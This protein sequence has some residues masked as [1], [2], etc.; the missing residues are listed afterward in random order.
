MFFAAM[1]V[2]M[3][4]VVQRII[5]STFGELNTEFLLQGETKTSFMRAFQV[6]R[7]IEEMTNLS[8]YEERTN[9]T[10]S[11]QSQKTQIKSHW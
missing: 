9:V 5:L 4:S 10:T 11:D 6:R 2:N 3:L 8:P 7:E 1:T